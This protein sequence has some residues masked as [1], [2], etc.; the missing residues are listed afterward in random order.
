[1][2][3]EHWPDICDHDVPTSGC[4]FCAIIYGVA[5]AA[6]PDAPAE[7]SAAPK[8]RGPVVGSPHECNCSRCDSAPNTEHDFFD[9]PFL[10]QQALKQHANHLKNA[11]WRAAHPPAPEPQMTRRE[12]EHARQWEE[13]DAHAR[14]YWHARGEA[15]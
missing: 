15:Y 4:R 13:E 3:S 5:E 14:R 9:S 1:M 11:A 6:A 7:M 2:E 12:W 8:Y 10:Q